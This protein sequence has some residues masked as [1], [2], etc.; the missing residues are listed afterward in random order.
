MVYAAQGPVDVRQQIHGY[1]AESP[2]I[3]MHPSTPPYRLTVMMG[4]LASKVMPNRQLVKKLDPK[5]LSRDPV[6][7]RQFIDDELCHDTGT[8]ES[9]AGMLERAAG[10]EKGAYVI[11]NSVGSGDAVMKMR[12]W[13]SHGTHDGVCDFDG[14]REWFE[15]VDVEDKTFKIYDGWYHKC[16]FEKIREKMGDSLI[17]V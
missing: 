11:P 10:L 6:V 15:Q 5:L 8:L 16:M 17:I 2:F 13:I 9:L 12:L 3:S 4:K 14:T 1:L 7:Q